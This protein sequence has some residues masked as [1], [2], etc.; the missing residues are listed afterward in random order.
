MKSEDSQ[1]A[2]V[3]PLPAEDA[4]RA[5]IYALIGRLFYNAPDA[6]LLA[7]ISRSETEPDA[8]EGS[9]GDAWRALRE[10][11][12]SAYPVVVKQE[13]DNLFA[14]VGKSEITPYT[15][16]YVKDAAPDRHLVRLRQLLESLNLVRRDAAFETEDHVSGVCDV[17]R[18]LVGEGLPLEE[19]RL[20]FNEFA[21][22][23]VVPFCE[24]VQCSEH[25]TFYRCVAQFARAFLE[26]EK[27]A[28]GMDDR[29]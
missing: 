11:C 8:A 12:K 15:S 3:V 16:H 21:F 23:G 14:G 24:A 22:P 18:L 2:D 4:A 27:V 13:F 17:M 9:M 28:F 19:Q 10:A 20:F 25:A 5:N 29:E 1:A 7:E 26:I 6:V